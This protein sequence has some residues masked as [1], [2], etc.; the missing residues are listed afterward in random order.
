MSSR[1]RCFL[2]FT[3]VIVATAAFGDPTIVN[4]NF[5]AVPIVCSNGYAYQGT[6]GCTAPP[7]PHQDYNSTPGFGWNLGINAGLT[8]PGTSFLPPPFIGL[9]FTQAVFLQGYWVGGDV[10]S[11]PV[12]GFLAGSYT[13]SFYLGSRYSSGQYDGNQTVAA[14]IDGNVIGTWALTSYTPFTL[15][16]VTFTVGT[17]G[18][19]TLEF[20]GM[21]SGDHTAFL[22][23]VSITQTGPTGTTWDATRDF[24]SSNPNGAWSYGDGITGTS[25]TLYP[26][27]NPDCAD[28]WGASGVVC[29][30]AEIFDHD[31]LVSFNTTGNWLNFASVVDP[32]NVLLIHPGPNDGQD[33]IV[34]W[35]APVAG[36]YNISGFF[37]I[38][39]TNPTGILGLV[40]ENGTLIYSGEL[41]GPPAQHPNQVGG[42]ENFNFSTLF[43]NAGDVISFGVNKDGVFQDDSTGFN[44]TITKPTTP[45]TLCSH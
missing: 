2:L 23:Y 13:L 14:L 25:F 27:Y 16:T 38:L 26:F 35:T 4:F 28:I 42:Q 31:P 34:R 24:S 44:V 11:Q 1:L 22:S 45:C 39:D 15:E 6:T 3:L 5:G 40:F 33:T 20:R 8:G 18:G 10:V 12:G 41:L 7:A 43:L 17:G 30:T 19:H 29:W 36:Y 9:P 32:P 37:E 21:N